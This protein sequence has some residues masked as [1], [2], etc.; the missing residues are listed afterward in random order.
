MSETKWNTKKLVAGT[1]AVVLTLAAAVVSNVYGPKVGAAQHAVRDTT[2]A[3][4]AVVGVYGALLLNVVLIFVRNRRVNGLLL[5]LLIVMEVGG[6]A[7]LLA[8]GMPH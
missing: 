6:S 2:L 8:A 7:A 5:A 1:A 4:V 3:L